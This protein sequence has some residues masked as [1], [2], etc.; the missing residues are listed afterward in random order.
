[1]ENTDPELQELLAAA[2][3]SD[4]MTDP[5]DWGAAHFHAGIACLERVIWGVQAT[6]DQAIASFERALEI[7]P[8]EEAPVNG[9]QIA[10]NLGTCYLLR[11]DGDRSADIE[12][13]IWWYRRALR[14]TNRRQRVL[15]WATIMDGLGQA[16]RQRIGGDPPRN[17]DR[18]LCY[19]RIALRAR[20]PDLDLVG[21][22]KTRLN[23]G[24]AYLER[25]RGE[26]ADNA[27]RAIQNL[28]A[29]LAAISPYRYES[30]DH[31]E[32]LALVHDALGLAYRTRPAGSPEEDRRTA[33]DHLN[34]ALA[35]RDRSRVPHRWA[36]SMVN[37]GACYLAERFRSA[38][39]RPLDVERAIHCA[40]EALKV[41]RAREQP[42]RWATAHY[43]LGVG[44]LER[45][46]G[47]VQLNTGEA[48]RHLRAALR[49]RTRRRDPLEWAEATA[50]LGNA[51][52]K[53]IDD[54]LAARRAISCYRRALRVYTQD[55]AFERRRVLISYGHFYFERSRWQEAL[56]I[57]L[58]AIEIGVVLVEEAYTA[59][60]RRAEVAQLSRIYPNVVYALLKLD[61]PE[62]A[63]ALLEDGKAR[64]L[65][66]ALGLTDAA[67]HRLDDAARSDLRSLRESVRG[68]EAELSR[69]LST[70]DEAAADAA[71]DG[72][73]AARTMLRKEIAALRN[74]RP[75]LL[76]E[77][78]T[79]DSILRLVGR[80]ECLVAPVL[81]AMGGAV[82][83]LFSGQ[84]RIGSHDVLWLD[85]AGA[86]FDLLRPGQA[87]ISDAPSDSRIW[88]GDYVRR[89]AETSERTRQE[90]E[91]ATDQLLAM[92]WDEFVGPVHARLQGTDTEELVI[93]PQGGLQLL[94]LHAAWRDVGGS[95]RYLMDDY[96]VRYAP[97]AFVLRECQARAADRGFGRTL[98]AAVRTYGDPRLRPLRY[99]GVEAAGVA[100]VTG[101]E[102][103]ADR[104]ASAAAVIARARN[105]SHLH[106]ACHAST[107]AD[108][109]DA[110]LQLGARDAGVRDE[111]PGWRIV[112]ELDLASARLVTLAACE[113]GVVDHE[114]SP[115]E[116]VGLPGALLQAG[117]A[118]VISSLW[119][120]NDLA[121]ALLWPA[122]YE[123]HVLRGDPPAAA[124]RD[125]Q[126]WLRDLKADEAREI[127]ARWRE[128]G[129]LLGEDDMEAL[130]RRTEGRP[131]FAHPS[132]WAAFTCVGA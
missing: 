124:L 118:G 54:P 132:A 11:A 93:L 80:G 69:R 44:Y 59:T 94:P 42:E 63:L 75:G 19:L 86:L 107:A 24:N 51:H 82:F 74:S 91:D 96:T 130:I 31:A 128:R 12:A 66:E 22:V 26:P 113:S 101:G 125:A 8:P 106:F 3:R 112:T 126:L 76:F 52:A 64:L 116:Y 119:A 68:L 15:F 27:E 102:V 87:R 79:G 57:Y 14:A 81:T 65:S 23:I 2:A 123:R 32:S 49:V 1:M 37:L 33:I 90:R 34:D 5:E 16:F 73:R 56:D 13:C 58:R 121:C 97:S 35:I 67:L 62:D 92:L 71:R 109:L 117:G 84:N 41:L 50:V 100:E 103:L 9:S 99:A 20:T 36:D 89:R 43:L 55:N 21:H 70:G 61:R 40:G 110:A 4:R 85:G 120:V 46:D 39:S 83:L 18:A 45:L 17:R 98:V 72:L 122:F 48:I 38:P 53:L 104:E 30:P 77:P 114:L 60:G 115:D 127:T 108:P 25:V 7:W 111:L 88:L 29:A 131:P 78:L 28:E 95:R 10:F 129:F 105:R 6:V 47:D